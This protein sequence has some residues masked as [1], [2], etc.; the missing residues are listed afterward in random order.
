MRPRGKSERVMSG[1]ITARLRVYGI[2]I[3]ASRFEYLSNV[4]DG[5]LRPLSRVHS[6][7]AGSSQSL[8]QWSHPSRH[9]DSVL[10]V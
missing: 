10:E 8:C 6:G 3:A 4:R 1:R 7:G 2:G 5:W 9:I